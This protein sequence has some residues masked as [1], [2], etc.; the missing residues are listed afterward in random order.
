MKGKGGWGREREQALGAHTGRN[1]VDINTETSNSWFPCVY[2]SKKPRII[3]KPENEVKT[4]LQKPLSFHLALF[5]HLPKDKYILFSLKLLT[6]GLA[7]VQ[8]WNQL[9]L[10]LSPDAH[11]LEPGFTHPL[12][13]HFPA[14][15]MQDNCLQ[16]P[17]TRY[18]ELLFSYPG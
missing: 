9:S 7:C 6:P 11:Q 8:K 15:C 2:I 14:C 10:R 16:T 18:S 3:K 17:I 5:S 4:C 13:P 1:R 12:S